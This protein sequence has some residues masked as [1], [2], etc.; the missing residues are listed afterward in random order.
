MEI[1][2]RFH[3]LLSN[4]TGNG[5]VDVCREADGAVTYCWMINNAEQAIVTVERTYVRYVPRVE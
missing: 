5:L 2:R 3:E 1:T 4:L